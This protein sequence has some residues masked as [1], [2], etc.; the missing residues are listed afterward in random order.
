ICYSGTPEVMAEYARLARDSGA[1]VIGGCCGTTAAHV[2]AMRAALDGTERGPR[3]S[4]AEI[5]AT[6]GPV[7]LPSAGE[8]DR[9]ERR[10]RRA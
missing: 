9:A 8:P 7:I 3:P 2:A 1:R 10:R 6:L 5:S 4:I